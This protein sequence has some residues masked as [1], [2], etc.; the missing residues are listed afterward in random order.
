M[1]P[2]MRERGAGLSPLT[3]LQDLSRRLD[4]AMD[5]GLWNAGWQGLARVPAAD[6]VERSDAVHV[7]IDAPGRSEEDFDLRFEG[8]ILT[9]S[10]DAPAREEGEEDDEVRAWRREWT[11]GAWQRSFT[12]PY[13]ID[14]DGIRATYDRG[15]LEIV[16]PKLEEARPRRVPVS[17]GSKRRRLFSGKEAD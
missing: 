4:D 1:L 9:V 8:G 10:A 6:L 16:L 3:V 2:T 14:A 5:G 15:V 11:L 13:A 12:L 17:S 7:R